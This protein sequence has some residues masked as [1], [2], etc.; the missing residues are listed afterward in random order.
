[1]STIFSKIIKGEISAF[2]VLE[3]DKHLAFL[4]VFPLKRGHVLV[5]PKKE[6]DYIFDMEDKELADLMMFAKEVSKKIEK[7]FPCKKVGV[8]VIGLEIP[9]THIHLMP[10]ESV[11]DINF[12]KPKIKIESDELA[13][14]ANQIAN[15]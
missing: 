6:V 13:K 1:M 14:I 4:D 10:L 9:H 11:S 7:V 15:A 12:E 8:A 5:I 3:D 2:K